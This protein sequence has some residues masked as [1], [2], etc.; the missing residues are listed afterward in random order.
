MKDFTL[1]ADTTVS[2][3][4]HTKRKGHYTFLKEKRVLY[5]KHFNIFKLNTSIREGCFFLNIY[6]VAFQTRGPR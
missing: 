3:F 4:H 1:K 5:L 6:R 2:Q